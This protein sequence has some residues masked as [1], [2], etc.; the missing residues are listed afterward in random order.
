MVRESEDFSK[1]RLMEFGKSMNDSA[2][3]INKLL[4]NL[5]DW[6]Q[7]QEGTLSFFSGEISL[8]EVVSTCNNILTRELSKKELQTE[9]RDNHLRDRRWQ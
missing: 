3:I 8:S 2:A 6:T 1:L 7:M 4:E 5:L 9:F